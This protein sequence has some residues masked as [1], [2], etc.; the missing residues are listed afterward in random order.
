LTKGRIAA[1]PKKNCPFLWEKRGIWPH[2]LHDC[3]GQRGSILEVCTEVGM[4]EIPQ[5]PREWRQMLH[6]YCAGWKL[7]QREY[8]G[9]AVESFRR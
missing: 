3:L 6:E 5:I 2:L 8:R 7:G 1:P 9:D 4:A